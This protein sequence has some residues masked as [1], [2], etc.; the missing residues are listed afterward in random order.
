MESESIIIYGAGGLGREVAC[1]IKVINSEKEQWK[2]LG[3]VD[4]SVPPGTDLTYGKVLGKCDYLNSY[5]K[6][7]AVVIAVGN[8]TVMRTI[9]DKIS[10]HNV[11]FPTI[12]APDVKIFDKESVIIGEGNLITFGCRIS[13]SVSIGNFNLL[14]GCVSLGHDVKLGDF[15]VLM[16][17]VR[18]SGETHI[19]KDNFL[20][21][22]SFVAQRLRIGNRTKISAGSIVMR[23]TK[24]NALYMG[25]PAQRIKI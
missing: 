12:I 24:D 20:G 3:F 4:D 25:N 16:P 11:W 21:A 7:V 22:R 18:V 5:D 2:F 1:L 23:N 15:N 8:P 13:C 6:K 17:D 10:N 19:G 9:Y 14:N